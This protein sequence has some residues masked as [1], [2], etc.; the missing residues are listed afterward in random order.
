MRHRPIL[1]G[2]AALVL[3]AGVARVAPLRAQARRDSLVA[4]ASAEFD[5]GRR[6]QLLVSAVSL[7]LG[8]PTE[9]PWATAVQLLAQT[10]IEEGQD[11]EAA[12]WLRWAV[13]LA[14]DLQ[15]DTVQSLPQVVT[16]FRAARQFVRQ[17]TTVQD[18][19]MA[20]SWIWPASAAGLETGRMQIAASA[21]PASAQLTVEGIG[22]VRAGAAQQLAPGS[23]AVLAWAAGYDSVRVTREVLPG[24]TTLLRPNLRLAPTPRVPASQSQIAQRPHKRFPW[25]IAALGVVGAGGVVALLAGGGGGGSTGGTG[26]IIIHFPN[27]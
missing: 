9:G 13:R 16:A 6:V 2:V 15:P 19:A 27:P 23:Y 11:A 14:P 21:V 20:T 7:D 18:S 10:L 17:T 4:A 8:P 24:V 12:A 22:V 1:R 5:A 25:V 26:G 3:L